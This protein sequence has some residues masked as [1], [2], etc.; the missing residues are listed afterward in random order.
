[1]LTCR[2]RRMLAVS[3]TIWAQFKE[4]LHMHVARESRVTALFARRRVLSCSSVSCVV[5]AAQLYPA[6][7]NVKLAL[8]EATKMLGEAPGV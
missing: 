6:D 4:I 7:E 3:H 5:Q 8:Q 2:D 1:M